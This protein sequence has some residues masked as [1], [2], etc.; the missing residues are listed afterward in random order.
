MPKENKEKKKRTRL[1]AIQKK[2]I[3]DKKKA[4]PNLL[5]EEIAAEFNCDRSTV[6]KILKQ[7]KWSEVQEVSRTANALKI[8]GPKFS[9]VEKALEMWISTAEQQQLTLTGDVIRQKALDFA[10]LLDIPEE[11][12]KASQGWLS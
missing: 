2:Q 8:V 9:Q 1:T 12:F 7:E 5:D 6:S 11:E 3:Q 10:T 4:N